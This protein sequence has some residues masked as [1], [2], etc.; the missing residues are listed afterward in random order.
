MKGSGPTPPKQLS[1]HACKQGFSRGW[2]G[3]FF[4]LATP[5]SKSTSILP[6]KSL[7]YNFADR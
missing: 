5:H 1:T 2:S 4:L 3:F 7:S 6:Q